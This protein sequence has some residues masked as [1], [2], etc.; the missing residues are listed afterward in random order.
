MIFF[1]FMMSS[2]MMSLQYRG[3]SLK[4]LETVLCLNSIRNSFKNLGNQK[5]F[6]C[7]ALENYEHLIFDL[8]NG[9]LESRRFNF[10]FVP[11]SILHSSPYSANPFVFQVS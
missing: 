6:S 4:I 2:S 1:S 7:K 9:L 8:K 11:G 5:F 3:N 10:F